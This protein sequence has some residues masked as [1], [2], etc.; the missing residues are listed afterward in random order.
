[1]HSI[2]VGGLD[3]NIVGPVKNGWVTYDRSVRPADV[4]GEQNNPFLSILAYLGPYYGRAEDMT[5]IVESRFQTF[6]ETYR[7]PVSHRRKKGE[8]SFG[9]SSRI[10][11]HF[12]IRPFATLP[13]V[14]S[15]FVL[16]VL[17]LQMCPGLTKI[18]SCC[19]P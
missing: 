12:R 11:R 9:V 7:L 10:K 18:G 8:T 19:L 2:A 13:L 16:G 4:T 3:E 1:M 15:A 17:L 14:S 6:T 5:C